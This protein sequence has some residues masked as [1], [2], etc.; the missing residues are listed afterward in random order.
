MKRR[1]PLSIGQII[2]KAL[3]EAGSADEVAAH[4]IEAA[5]ADVVGQGINRMTYRRVMKGGVLHVYMSSAVMKHE[6]SFRK[7]SLIDALCR[8]TAS[9]MLTDIQFH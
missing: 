8:T 7:Q 4:R 2:E 1:E 9:K 6:L 3:A 5:W